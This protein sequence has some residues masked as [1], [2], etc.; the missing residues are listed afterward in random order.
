MNLF[1]RMNIHDDLNFA[2]TA[3]KDIN[4]FDPKGFFQGQGKKLEELVAA[5]AQNKRSRLEKHRHDAQKDV[6]VENC[7]SSASDLPFSQD[8]FTLL[9]EQLLKLSESWPVPAEQSNNEEV[10]NEILSLLENNPPSTL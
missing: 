4:L 3:L 7:P 5:T 1:Q 8:V 2:I 6:Q 9:D 10:W